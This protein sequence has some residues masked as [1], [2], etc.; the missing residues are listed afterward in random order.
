M[1]WRDIL[2]RLWLL[3]PVSAWLPSNNRLKDLS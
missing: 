2:S 3:D 1:P